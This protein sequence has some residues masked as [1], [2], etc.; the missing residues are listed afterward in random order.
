[1]P[2]QKRSMESVP[3]SSLKTEAHAYITLRKQFVIARHF[4]IRAKRAVEKAEAVES[5][6]AK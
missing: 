3:A 2:V 6:K 4:G 5:E 1:M